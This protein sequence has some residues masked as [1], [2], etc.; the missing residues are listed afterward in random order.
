MNIKSLF[1]LA[2]CAIIPMAV[3]S[4]K[5]KVEE[6]VAPVVEEVPTLSDEDCAIQLSLMSESVKNKQY[7]D[8]Y[9]PWWTLYTSRPDFNK[10]IYTQGSKIIEWKLMKA[11]A[12]SERMQW[13]KILMES[14]DKRIQYFGNDAK[15][16]KDYILGEKGL[17]YIENYPEDSVKECA[18][19]WLKQS[20]QALTTNSKISVLT[21]LFETSYY[22]YRSNPDKYTNTIMEDYGLVSGILQQINDNPSSKFATAAAQQKEYIDNLFA[23]SGAA[24][25]DKLD[26]LYA[27]YIQTNA[28]YLEDMLKVIKLYR[29]VSCTSSEVYFAAAAAAHKL[30]P[31]EESAAACASMCK[32]RGDWEGAINYYKEALDLMDENSDTQDRADYLYNIALISMDKLKNY[33]LARTMAR[34]S[35]EANPAQGRCYILIGLCYAATHPFSASIVGE[36]KAAILNKTVYWA[37]VDQFQKAKQV[38]PTCVE[39]ANEMI[40]SYSKYFPTKEEMFDLPNE[41]GGEFFIVGGWINE[42]TV[43]RPAK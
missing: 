34:Y 41:L 32:K 22:M 37:A 14:F 38:D 30:E 16:P 12:P 13:R 21:A 10:A 20:V 39:T 33:P 9:Q 27:E 7:D 6:E 15:Y 1:A 5:T 8:A 40:A 25:C 3:L 36:A 23:V 35:L 4:K 31:T 19:D 17:A 24:D 18:H 29:R 43:C 28:N 26:E 2:L 42:R 11:A